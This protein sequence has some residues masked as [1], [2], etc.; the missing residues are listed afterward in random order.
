MSEKDE[1]LDKLSSKL[2]E[3]LIEVPI[4]EPSSPYSKV[5]VQGNG[6]SANINFGTQ[7]NFPETPLP[8]PL[9]SAQRKELHEL[10]TRCEELGDDPRE[11]WRSVHVHLAVSSID[12][13]CAKDFQE[14][15][16]VLQSR[17]EQLQERSDRRRLTGKILQMSVEKDAKKEM[18]NFCDVTFG[19]TQLTQ[20]KRFELQQ[21]LGFIQDFNIPPSSPAMASAPQPS[22]PIRDFLFTYKWHSLGLFMLG[23][24]AGRFWL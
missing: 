15:R 1:K 24:F 13:I 12:E 18:N 8:R 6:N 23:V 20:L 9:L 14:A 5:E 19:R 3:G 21:V 17:L 7:L 22:L 2:I 11:A 10:R 16:S 4:T